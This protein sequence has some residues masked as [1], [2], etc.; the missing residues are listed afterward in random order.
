MTRSNNL[1]RNVSRIT[2]LVLAVSIGVVAGGFAERQSAESAKKTTISDKELSLML[3]H[4][5][6]VEKLE[7][8]LGWIRWMMSDKLDPKS[9]MTF[10]LV[11]LNAGQRNPVH[12]H[13]N[14]EEH[15]YVLSGTLEHR[16]ADK[17]IS[18]KKGD[19]LRIPMGV[20]HNAWT[21]DKEPAEAVIVYS[22]G[23]RQFEVVEEER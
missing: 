18:L 8:P 22:S 16:L 14:C 13:P 12:I 6:Q 2:F 5:D 20:A 15:L 21:T 7:H 1:R 4:F 3:Q 17:V 19:L 10:G 23:D 9:E 11:K